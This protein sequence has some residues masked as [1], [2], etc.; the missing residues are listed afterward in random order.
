MAARLLLGTM[1]DSSPGE[2]ATIEIPTMILCGEDDRDNGSPEKLAE[3][4]PHGHHV[5]IPGSHMSSVTES[6][7]GEALVEFLGG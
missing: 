3:T 1:E 5:A 2:L 7:L 6:A 4:L